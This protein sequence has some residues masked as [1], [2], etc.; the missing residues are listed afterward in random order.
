MGCIKTIRRHENE[1]LENK[2]NQDAWT[3]MFDGGED[4][5]DNDTDDDDEEVR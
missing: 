4:D 1:F 3:E 5:D 2:K